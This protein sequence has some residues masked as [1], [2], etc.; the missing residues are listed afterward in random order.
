[1]KAE[2]GKVNSE[3]Q[4]RE[5]VDNW[6]Q[7]VRAKDIEGLL[8]NYAPDIVAFD[9][10]PPLQNV[11]VEAYRKLWEMCFDEFPG[12]IGFEIRDLHISAGDEVAFCHHFGRFSGTSKKGEKIDNWMRGTVCFRKIDGKWLVTHEHVSVPIDMESSKG[13]FDLKP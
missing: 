5:L 1:M 6:V 10:M 4:I 12:S 3:A 2:K 7:A 9:V 11:G 8:A 13:L